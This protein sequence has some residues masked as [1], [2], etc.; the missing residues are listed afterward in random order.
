MEENNN[1]IFEQAKSY[2][3]NPLGI[4]ALFL[5]IIYATTGIVLSTRI[6]NLKT[7]WERM[8]LIIFVVVF[9]F[10]VLYVFY[11]LVVNHHHKL[12][13]PGEF[14]DESNFISASLA[15]KARES[16]RKP[17]EVI[18]DKKE[19]QMKPSLRLIDIPI[20][21]AWNLNHWGSRCASIM[22]NKI[23]F[24]G[25]TAPKGTDGCHIDLNYVLE[26]G[27]RYKVSCIA[28]SIAGTNGKFQ[29]WCHDETIDKP[30][31]ENVGTH[32][33]IPSVNGDEF[34]V[35]FNAKYNRN[36]RIHLQYEPGDGEI[37]VYNV[38]VEEL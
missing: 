14:K 21:K 4:I 22:N 20:N 25:K 11:I 18:E 33:L 19:I 26:L 5:S 31:G 36:I 16:I 17:S 23:I 3:K 38:K 9:P 12:Y 13:S 29:L 8:P 27:K 24:R 28:S 37:Q 10:V 34:Y 1:R 7:V 32:Y 6:D 35:E 15:W 30:I 2:V